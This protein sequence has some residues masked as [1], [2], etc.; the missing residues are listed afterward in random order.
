MKALLLG[1]GG[2][3]GRCLQAQWPQARALSRAALDLALPAAALRAQ[4]QAMGP[5]AVINA[6]AYTAVDAAES[7]VEA[8]HAIN[9]SACAV[10]GECAREWAQPLLHFSTEQVFEGSATRPYREDDAPAPANAYG[11]SK[12]AGEAA[13]RASGCRALIVRTSWL[14]A[15]HG[16][17]FVRS[18]WR[19]AQAE[20]ELRVVNDQFG[21]P[22]SAHWLAPASL[23]AWKQWQQDDLPLPV[24]HL[25]AAGRVSRAEL[26]AFILQEM[27]AQGLSVRAQLV[28]VPTAAYPLP[29]RRPPNGCLDT[30]LAA[31]RFGVTAPP[32]ED[33]VRQ[34]LAQW[35]P[36]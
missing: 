1:A 10:L 24:L 23:R 2:R 25:N 27:R 21:A 16:E 7:D 30:T 35:R 36:R 6:A 13:L 4:L 22:T 5:A 33:G 17:S 28:P 8:A 12:Q 32:W 31:T 29:A 20:G 18:I 11:R 14:F 34:V 15:A 26:A 3:L 19:A 9:A